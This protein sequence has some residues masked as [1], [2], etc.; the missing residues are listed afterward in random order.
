VH[1]LELAGPA[2]ARTFVHFHDNRQAVE[3][4]SPLAR[5][6]GARGHGVMLVEY[7]GYGAS[8]NSGDPSEAGVYLDAEAALDALRARG[9][10]PDRVV[11]SGASLG[12]GIAVEMARRG[13]GAA[14]LLVSPYTS[15]PDVVSDATWGL[16]PGRLVLADSFDTLDKLGSVRVPTLVVHGDADDIVPFWMG[17]R[18]ARGI[19]GA[20]LLRIPGGRHGDLFAREGATLFAAISDF[21]RG[22]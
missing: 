22:S 18:V 15:L 14:L 5:A 2:G 9:I 10:G 6:L 20:R 12:T 1:A 3:D 7:R 4:A 11:L 21:A 17:E 13:R 16:L 19:A 8:A